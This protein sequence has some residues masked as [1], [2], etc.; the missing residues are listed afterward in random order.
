MTDLFFYLRAQYIRRASISKKRIKMHEHRNIIQDLSC[1]GKG[2]DL[3]Y[4]YSL[5]RPFSDPICC[6]VTCPSCHCF[7]I[8]WQVKLTSSSR[9]CFFFATRLIPPSG[10]DRESI[11]F[12]ISSHG[13]SLIVILGIFFHGSSLPLVVFLF[14]ST[15]Y[16]RSNRSIV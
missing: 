14:V 4:L 2:F 7:M 9:F 16:S 13:I 1:T 6:T 10:R 11:K 3:Y 12:L 5:G 8:Y 15:V